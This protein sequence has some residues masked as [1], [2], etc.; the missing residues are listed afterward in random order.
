MPHRLRRERAARQLGF[1][2]QVVPPF[3]GIASC[4]AKF[5]LSLVNYKHG[6]IPAD[7]SLRRND[8]V[9]ASV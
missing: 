1:R 6:R 3:L 7:S 4:Q 9:G 8:E 5:C 2:W